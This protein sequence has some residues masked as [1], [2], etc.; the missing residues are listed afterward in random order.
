MQIELSIIDDDDA[1][2][3][4]RWQVMRSLL[5]EVGL[6]DNFQEEFKEHRTEVVSLLQEAEFDYDLFYTK[7]SSSSLTPDGKKLLESD[8]MRKKVEKM[9]D[10]VRNILDDMPPEKRKTEGHKI[11]ALTHIHIAGVAITDYAFL[12]T[13]SN[14]PNIFR[15]RTKTDAFKHSTEAC[16]EVY[17][18]LFP[19]TRKKHGVKMQEGAGKVRAR[20]KVENSIF[21]FETQSPAPTFVGQII[22]NRWFST[23]WKENRVEMVMLVVSGLLAFLLFWGTP[24]LT[25]PVAKLLAFLFGS[26]Q[27]TDMVFES[28]INTTMAHKTYKID[29][30][31]I[32]YIRSSLERLDTGFLV[33]FITLS[34]QLFTKGWQL[35]WGKDI[36]WKLSD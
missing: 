36:K 32:S 12:V 13:G 30:T 22:G 31:Y 24:Y 15:L 7:L 25:T 11:V 16:Q 5:N 28:W 33:A 6:R 26:W 10:D 23:L 27:H 18:K 17:N 1:D 8:L 2:E 3:N 35:S 34:I 20:I 19:L 9:C 4:Q 21:A 29:L 14:S